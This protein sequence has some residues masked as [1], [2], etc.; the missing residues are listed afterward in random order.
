[1]SASN[2]VRGGVKRV[3]RTAMRVYFDKIEVSNPKLVHN[4]SWHLSTPRRED[5]AT[6]KP[7]SLRRCPL[8]RSSAWRECPLNGQRV[9]PDEMSQVRGWRYLPKNTASILAGN[10]P[11]GLID[12]MVLMTALPKLELSSVAKQSLFHT[13]IV[14]F[15]LKTMRAVPV[16]KAYERPVAQSLLVHLHTSCHYRASCTLTRQALL[17]A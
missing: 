1:M 16:A 13:P 8:P 2:A 12:P 4:M 11:S 10:H 7:C 15:F 17:Q 14:S 6:T 5:T 3:I 9:N